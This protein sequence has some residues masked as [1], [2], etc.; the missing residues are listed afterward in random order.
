MVGSIER[1][2]KG[3][4]NQL[5]YWFLTPFPSQSTLAVWPTGARRSLKRAGHRLRR[6][7]FTAGPLPGL[8]ANEYRIDLVSSYY[9]QFLDRSAAADP[10]SLHWAAL[11]QQRV[12][13]QAVIAGILGSDEFYANSV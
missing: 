8:P 2:E 9:A 10:G 12:R 7:F 13:D 3:V 1:G 4:R 11:L 5:C 6:I